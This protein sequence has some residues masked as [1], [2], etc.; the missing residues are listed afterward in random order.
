[1]IWILEFNGSHETNLT[2]NGLCWNT[3]TCLAARQ[4]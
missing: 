1:V 3:V 2:N 4:I